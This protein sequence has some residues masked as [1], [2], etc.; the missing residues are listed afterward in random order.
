MKYPKIKNALLCRM[1]I[2]IVVIGGFLFPII[3]ICLM[4]FIP[5][6]A[7]ILISFALVVALIVYMVKNLVTLMTMDAT[8][9][10]VNCFRNAR[11]Q[12][13]LC[14][15]FSTRRIRNKVSRFGK[16]CESQPIF[17]QPDLLRYKFKSSWEIYSKGTEKV[18]ATYQ[19]EHLDKELYLKIFNSAKRNS[20]A[21]TGTKKPIFLDK[22]QK[23][24]PLKRITVAF[25]FAQ[26]IE[27]RFRSDMYDTLCKQ[28]GDEFNDCILPCVIDLER[29][30]CS[31][32]SV[33]FP[34][35]GFG[36]PAINI[37]IKLIIK[38]I[39][40]SKPSFKNNDNFVSKKFDNDLNDS[41]WAFW[42]T[43]KNEVVGDK[44]AR[45]KRFEKMEHKQI[46]FDKEDEFVYV[47]WE[48][49]GLWLSVILNEDTRIAEVDS[50]NS[51]DYPKSN[52]IAKNTIKEIEKTI[53]VG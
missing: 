47:K 24:A 52:M 44:K 45:R 30:L 10:F 9:A 53:S 11:T 36:Y 22:E 31:F 49:N 3:P 21:L 26:T 25:I 6:E 27:E 34:Y 42:K 23:K 2:Y 43:T 1:L 17:P 48:N 5:E 50:F 28:N 12:F 20:K 40:G 8:L 41:L 32:N 4:P 39:F 46:I 51:W 16:S 13:D 29:N 18:I 37:G 35:L 38:T 15:N 14:G 7:K 33:K 19:A